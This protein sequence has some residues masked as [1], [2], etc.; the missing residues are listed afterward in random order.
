MSCKHDVWFP[1][2]KLFSVLLHKLCKLEYIQ[3][4]Q[5][6]E[7]KPFVV[8]H[9][10]LELFFIFLC[11]VMFLLDDIIPKA[12]PCFRDAKSKTGK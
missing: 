3:S 5:E 2:C 11:Y 7:S 8:N 9:S 1:R 6:V 12:S 4:R 10:Q